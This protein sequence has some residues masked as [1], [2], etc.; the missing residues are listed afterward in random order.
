MV[1]APLDGSISIDD[2]QLGANVCPGA[3]QL[4]IVR[5]L[6]AHPRLEDERP[7]VLELGVELALQTEQD[8]ALHAPVIR[9]VTRRVLDDANPNARKRSG[10]PVRPPCFALVLGSLDA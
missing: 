5:D 4:G 9:N 8:V 7:P 3:V 2:E 6:V 1:K 10:L